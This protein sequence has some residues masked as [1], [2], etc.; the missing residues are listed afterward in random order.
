MLRSEVSLSSAW[1]LSSDDAAG[2]T[3]AES[4][5]SVSGELCALRRNEPRLHH[6]T[7]P[8][9]VSGSTSRWTTDT[10]GEDEGWYKGGVGDVE[11]VWKK[12]FTLST[13]DRVRFGLSAV[14]LNMPPG[15]VGSGIV[16]STGLGSTE[17]VFDEAA[18][19][20]RVSGDG[21][22]D[23]DRSATPALSSCS[24]L[25]GKG[26]AE[27]GSS[28][29]RCFLILPLDDFDRRCAII[30][31]PVDVVVVVPAVFPATWPSV[32][33]PTPPSAG[34]SIELFRL[35]PR[36]VLSC[37]LRAPNTPERL[38]AEFERETFP[39]RFRSWNSSSSRITAC[40][41]AATIVS[42]NTS[43][44][45][46]STCCRIWPDGRVIRASNARGAKNAF[47]DV[48]DVRRLSVVI[49]SSWR[50]IRLSARDIVLGIFR[51]D[52][53]GGAGAWGL[54]AAAST[55]V[56]S[57]DMDWIVGSGVADHSVLATSSGGAAA[58]AAANRSGPEGKFVTGSFV[59]D[60]E[61]TASAS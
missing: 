58:A 10:F 6:W 24:S 9:C 29:S 15:G 27:A 45:P 51:G 53:N 26:G 37:L 28:D 17:F 31:F 18:E 3:G 44:S 56:S 36:I 19:G 50:M 14:R 47:T 40:E 55:D 32:S 61:P 52:G 11:R 4:S 57:L 7:S 8:P 13:I 46:W 1:L 43:C 60:G 30:E 5:V 33:P 23:C 42:E 48:V 12:C 54:S 41:R 39:S 59:Q 20:P 22:D 25:I 35:A 34:T 21:E 38:S 16:I 49:D 2:V